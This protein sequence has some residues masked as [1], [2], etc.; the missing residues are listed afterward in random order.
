QKNELL[1]Q[2]G[3]NFNDLPAWQKQGIAVYWEEFDK[4]AVNPVTGEAVVALRRRLTINDQLPRKAE[5]TEF[6]TQLL[7]AS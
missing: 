2:R 5:Y 4:P 1:F 6:L 3:I 7:D